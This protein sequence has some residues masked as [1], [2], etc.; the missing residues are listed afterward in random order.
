MNVV[1]RVMEYAGVYVCV[2]DGN[3]MVTSKPAN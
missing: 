1:K 2:I 3:R